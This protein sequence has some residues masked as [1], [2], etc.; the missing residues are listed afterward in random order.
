MIRGL[1]KFLGGEP[2]EEKKMLLLLGKGFFMGIFLASYQIGAETLFL[3]ALGE[4]YLDI[5]FFTAGGLGII[6]TILFVKIQERINYSSLVVANVFF[7]FLFIVFLRVCIAFP[8]ML[9]VIGGLEFLPF[10]LFVMIGPITAV[11]LLGFWGIFGRIFD[12]KQSKR[13]IGGIDTGQLTATIIAFFSIPVLNRIGIVDE[14][15]D[16]LFMAGIASFGMFIFTLWLIRSYNMDRVTKVEKDEEKQKVSFVGLFANPYLRMLSFFIIFSMAA[17]VFMNYTFYT[18]TEEMFPEEEKLRDFLSFFNGTIMILSFG[19]QSFVND[20]IINNF[21][22]R[23]ALMVMPLVLILFTIG[24]II[25]GNIYGVKNLGG[26][27]FLYFFLFTALGKLFTASLKD[28]LENPAFKLF[29]LPLDRKI[30]FDVQT[31]IEGVINEFATLL[32]GAL[33]I[34]LGVLA[35]VELIHYTYFIVAMAGVVIL[36]ANKL[37]GQYKITLKNTLEIQKLNLAEEDNRN[38]VNIINALKTESLS[39]DPEE[40][41]HALQIL[42]KI[43][44]IQLES[45]LVS[46]L[47]SERKRVRRYAYIKLNELLCFDQLEGLREELKYEDDPKLME[48]GKKVV[49]NLE[50]IEKYELKEASIRKLIRSTESKDRIMAAR[51]LVKMT[52][53]RYVP[54]LM[55]LL[56]DINSDVRIAAMVTAGKLHRPEFWPLLIE[57]LHL[58]T[59]GNIAMASLVASGEDVFH[60]VDSSFYKTNQHPISIFRVIQIIGRIG[61]YRATDLLWKKID[62][63]N[64]RIV[65]EILVTLS[66][67]NFEAKDFQSARIKIFITDLIGNITWNLKVLQEIPRTEK[68]DR[69]IRFA[70]EEENKEAYN[71]IFMLLSMI[72]DPQSVHLIKEN[73]EIGT[74]DSVA[75]GIEMLDI[76]VEDELKPILFPA[77]D[78]ANIDDRLKLLHDHFAPEYFSSYN[79]L[80]LQIINRDYNHINRWTK[81]LAIHRYGQLPDTEVNYDLIANVFNPDYFIRETVCAVIYNLDK[82]AY[83][84]HTRR[85]PPNQKNELDKAILPPIFKK[86]DEDYH[87]KM[88]LI[89]LALYLHSLP[90]FDGVNG[91][92]ITKLAECVDEV[93]LKKGVK[94]IE[95]GEPGSGPFYIVW[96]GSVEIEKEDGSTETKRPGEVFGEKTILGN[97]SFD[98]NATT[99]EDCLLLMISKDEFFDL[100]TSNIDLL[101]AQ[102]KIMADKRKLTVED[103]EETTSFSVF[104][105]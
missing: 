46:S 92:T 17:S 85:I 31:R 95:K 44:P 52:Q 104:G 76:F 56:R 45:I 20:W 79:D 74:T 69:L 86:Q 102:L 55:E 16:L 101:F 66:Y 6:S 19:I 12:L 84:Y 2:G 97:T 78:D 77:L 81:V 67:L 93:S 47:Q 94:I 4:S 43:D 72:Y 5:A 21:G 100:I 89:E 13:I 35:F 40:V 54:Y 68:I 1:I 10:V 80:L 60:L 51:L 32:A 59:Y 7:T 53:E 62:Y 28:A 27:E 73:I 8:E 41:I 70:I 49:Q 61:G 26:D 91:L 88:T 34:G 83:N 58:A 24:A 38:E 90:G 14:T 63:P 22:L 99:A 29:F 48:L 30:R 103:A 3:N 71:D 37:F 42:E 50:K 15:Y 33:Q 96:Q 65:S 39:N 9:K 11:T 98:F 23:V 64:K 75:F 25:T 57:N 87:Q 105:E 36:L 18:A 82:E